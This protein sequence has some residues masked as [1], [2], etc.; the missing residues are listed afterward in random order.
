MTGVESVP[1]ALRAAGI[2][3]G[4]RLVLDFGVFH[5]L[6]DAQRRA[7]A[8]ELTEVAAP[9]TLLMIAFAPARRGPLPRGA[10]RSEIEGTYPRWNIIAEDALPVS[11]LPAMLRN[12]D[13]RVYRLRHVRVN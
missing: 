1:K 6:T 8:G 13:P 2:G 4:F 9:A 5:G 11:A 10:S 7:M 3:S 12:A